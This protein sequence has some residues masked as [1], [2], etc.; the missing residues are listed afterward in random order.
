MKFKTK[1]KNKE[2]E[3]SNEVERARDRTTKGPR[4]KRVQDPLPPTVRPSNPFSSSLNSNFRTALYIVGLYNFY[5]LRASPLNEVRPVSHMMSTLSLWKTVAPS[6]L[7]SMSA[8][9]SC[10]VTC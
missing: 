4:S 1:D 9:I 2:K 6:T 7:V 5:I 3:N 8:L 10:V